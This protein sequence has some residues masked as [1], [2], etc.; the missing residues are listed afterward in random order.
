[1]NQLGYKVVATDRQGHRHCSYF[2]DKKRAKFC[3]S[4]IRGKYPWG[5]RIKIEP[6]FKPGYTAEQQQQMAKA[7][8]GE[9]EA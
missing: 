8:S 3:A 1:M 4:E 9:G 2:S 5:N 7:Q 6:W